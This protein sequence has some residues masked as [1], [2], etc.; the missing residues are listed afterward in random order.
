MLIE[1]HCH[2]SGVSVCANAAAEKV[3]S[4]YE[5]AGYD[6]LVL[7]NHYNAHTLRRL[8]D[9]VGHSVERYIGEC[10]AAMN[11][12]KKLRVFF[13]AEVALTVPSGWAEFLLYGLTDDFLR[14]HPALYELT[15][16]QL[17]EL[18]DA[19][20][21]AMIQAHPFRAEQGHEP[22]DPACMHGLEINCHPD[23]LREEEKTRAFVDRYGL[24][25]TCG[26]DYHGAGFRPIGGIETE[27]VASVGELAEKIR[28]GD[29]RVTIRG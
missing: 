6:A 29:A 4:V 7:T 11:A 16:R 17:F 21:I 24:V 12:A 15:Q 10:R 25:V 26:S 1:T 5:A 3:V 8:G 9:T 14:A 13:G 2:S 23:F 19:N 20:D 27:P 22:Q 28:K 18:C